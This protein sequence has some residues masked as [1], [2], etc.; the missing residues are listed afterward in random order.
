MALDAHAQRR[1]RQRVQHHSGSGSQSCHSERSEESQSFRSRQ[2]TTEILH[3]A[4]GNKYERLNE[5][6]KQNKGKSRKAIN[7]DIY[8]DGRLWKVVH[9]KLI[10]GPGRPQGVQRLFR[11]VAEMLPF[12]A[13]SA[14]KK[15]MRKQNLPRTG[16]YMA[17][18]SMGHARYAGRG[19]IFTRLDKRHKAHPLEL[20]YF[21]FY[22]VLDKKHEREIETA[23]IRV[24]GP[25]LVF[26][27]QK[28]RVTNE[29]G[30]I[31]DYEPGTLFYVRQKKKGKKPR[32]KKK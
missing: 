24:A 3:Y 29:P 8:A 31:R 1:L 5:M 12:N 30:S 4:Q 23:L 11:V 25:Q 20:E 16:I 28:K 26:N 7:E 10:P 32:R 17:H 14:V 22:V 15:H 13:L 2:Q 21:S 27:T 18:D 19:N 9:G 6:A